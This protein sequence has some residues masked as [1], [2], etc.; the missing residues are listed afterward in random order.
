[1]IKRVLSLTSLSSRRVIA[2][3]CG[4]TFLDCMKV[5]S[6]EFM[7]YVDSDVSKKS[8]CNR[9]VAHALERP[10]FVES[11]ATDAVVIIYTPNFFTVKTSLEQYGFKHGKD[12][13]YF[14]DFIEYSAVF[15]SI[16][17]EKEYAFLD[18][19]IQPSDV[20]FDIG[21]NVG[22]YACKLANLSGYVGLNNGCHDAC[23]VFAF[24]PIPTN[25]STLTYHRDLL[26]ISNLCLVNKAVTE[27]SGMVIEMVMPYVNGIPM[28][29]H[30][31]IK[32]VQGQ[33]GNTLNERST[34]ESSSFA[35]DSKLLV[36]T[37]SVDAFS[38]DHKLTSLRYM[39]IDVEGAED[40]VLYGAAATLKR[41]NPI[42]QVE[43]AFSSTER[44][45]LL[46]KFMEAL[47][48]Q[49]MYLGDND[50]TLIHCSELLEGEKNYFF[51]HE[52]HMKELR[53]HVSNQ[54]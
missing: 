39:K 44:L 21:A 15:N 8:V 35:F 50:F 23:S 51:L 22:L 36:D 14:L 1:M 20:C 26:G 3:G 29:G 19:I 49:L 52:S 4:Q 41:F 34:V 18:R 32:G 54:T 24:E 33:I 42:V 46:F 17:R 30:S 31:H 43:I 13:F 27:R 5:K 45:Q 25:Y 10:S 12:F 53:E 16:C 6:L 28:T 47:G 48:Y 40:Q 7:A 37:I 2:W 38:L 9:G 11:M